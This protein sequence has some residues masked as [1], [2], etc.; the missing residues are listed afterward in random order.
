VVPAALVAEAAGEA[1]RP[2]VAA[3]RPG[4]AVDP[5]Q[6]HRGGVVQSSTVAKELIGDAEAQV[7]TFVV[8]GNG[9][10]TLTEQLGE[11]KQVKLMA[12]EAR[13]D[14]HWPRIPT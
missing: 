2:N 3:E 9:G 4:H 7:V 11:G 8:G 1:H 14:Q 10:V 5:A 6:Q 12:L 13:H